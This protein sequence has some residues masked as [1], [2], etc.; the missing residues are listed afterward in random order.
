M[1]DYIITVMAPDRIGIVRDVSAALTSVGGNIT[2]LSQTV[3]R[4]YFTLIISVQMPDDRTHAEIRQA[5]ERNGEVG[6]LEVIVK[7]YKEI[8]VFQTLQCEQFTLSMQ[9]TDQKGIIARTTT[10]LAESGINVDDFYSYVHE[11]KLLML[12]HV[13][14]PEGADIDFIQ[15]G[16]HQVGRDFNLVV[17][18]QHIDIF[19][20]TGDVHSVLD[21]QRRPI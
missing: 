3:L 17:H 13:S 1:K 15:D 19:R 21:I 5:V 6:E 9:G 20:V 7:P 8:P 11:G 18:F 12:A 2:H 16:L 14:V 4:N 10:Y